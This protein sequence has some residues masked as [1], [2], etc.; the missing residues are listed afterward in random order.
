[1]TRADITELHYIT[2]IA[3]VASI[4][5]HGILSH[6]R[7]AGFAHDS[8]AMAEI[9]ERRAGKSIPGARAL[10]EY[11]NLYFDAHN[12]MLSRLRSRNNELCVLRIDAA[13]LDISGVIV[14]D[15]NAAS[16]YARFYG[17]AEGLAALNKERVFAQYWTHPDD[18][19]VE[20]AHKL[21]K[22]AEVLVPDVFSPRYIT[23][24]LVSN[25][26]AQD[27]LIASGITLPVLVQ[28]TMFF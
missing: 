10:H 1:M 12:P 7:S 27:A 8:V 20:M 3:N 13:V 2:P 19:Y 14:A 22:C 5:C 6:A 18:P 24:A 17:V 26:Q 4:V 15:R 28:S 16:D 21:E 11:V 9:Q 25:K 23:G